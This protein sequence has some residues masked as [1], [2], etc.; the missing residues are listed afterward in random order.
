MSP[1]LSLL[2]LLFMS[3]FLIACSPIVAMQSNMIS[4]LIR[5]LPVVSALTA[6][7]ALALFAQL[8]SQWVWPIL[9]SLL[10]FLGFPI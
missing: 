8:L 2:S 10:L 9:H 7:P 4:S 5:E 6:T 1:T 3:F